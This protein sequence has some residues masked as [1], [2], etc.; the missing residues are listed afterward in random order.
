MTDKRPGPH[1]EPQREHQIMAMLLLL[2]FS[3]SY[4]ESISVL[5][6][7]EWIAAHEWGWNSLQLQAELEKCR[8]LMIQYDGRLT[9]WFTKEGMEFDYHCTP[10]AQ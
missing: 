10:P 5:R 8:E 4:E 6:G 7:L 2:A 3:S 9:Y 1:I